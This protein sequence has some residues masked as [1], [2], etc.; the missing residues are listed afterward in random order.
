[1]PGV[2]FQRFRELLAGFEKLASIQEEEAIVVKGECVIGMG[3]RDVFEEG[4]CASGLAHL[5]IK[6]G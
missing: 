6:H 5:G 3:A 4:T 1:V 2:S